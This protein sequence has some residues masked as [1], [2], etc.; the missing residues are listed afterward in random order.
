MIHAKIR[1]SQKYDE[2]WGEVCVGVSVSGKVSERSQ[3]FSFSA[4]LNGSQIKVLIQG[5]FRELHKFFLS[6]NSK[7]MISE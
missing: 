7:A 6:M 5:Q 1:V 4:F 3:G 2:W